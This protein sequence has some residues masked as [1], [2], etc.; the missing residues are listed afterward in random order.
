MF[1]SFLKPTIT[2]QT[3]SGS[4]CT[5]NSQYAGL[6][7]KSHTVDIDSVNGYSA[8]N[9]GSDN[10]Y[11]EFITWNQVVED[12]G[13]SGQSNNTDTAPLLRFQLRADGSPYTSYWSQNIS[14]PTT[15]RKLIKA[16]VASNN[17]VF[18][19]NGSARNL[20]FYVSNYGM[21]AD[22]I[23]YL[24]MD[25]T[26]VDIS[27]VGGVVW[28]DL[29][30]IDLTV[31]FGETKA[32]EIYSQGEVSGIAYFRDLF[33]NDYYSHNSGTLSTVSAVNGSTNSF[34]T[35]PIGQTVNEGEYNA[36]TGVLEVTQPSVQIL[37]L[38]PCPIDTLQ[39]VNNI[40]ADTGDTTLQY[41]KFG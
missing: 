10:K 21:I 41:P 2:T 13:I 28:K 9:I 6:P 39:G 5:F 23:Y 17:L 29:Q 37:Q 40:W 36:R 25:F 31:V 18:M 4:V 12:T 24:N 7:L 34:F 14:E 16:A 38:P 35:I 15:I 1:E 30:L 27:T 11:A 3:V 8:I 26:G 19:H 33:P 32:N 20:R 22:H